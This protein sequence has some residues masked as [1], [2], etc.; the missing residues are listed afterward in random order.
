MASFA[1]VS[2][3]QLLKKLHEEWKDFI[4][5]DCLSSRHALN[6]ILTAY[7]LHEWVWAE[8]R[9]QRSYLIARWGFAEASRD[10]TPFREYITERC[11]AFDDARKIANGW[12]HFHTK[13]K[14]GQHAGAFQ[15][16]FVN[17]LGFDVDYLWIER[18][19]HEQRAEDFIRGLVE[20]WDGFFESNGL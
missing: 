7:H 18:D 14:T 19:G 13:V 1:I 15:R 4:A 6:A 2:P 9:V 8:C 17:D 10:S 20:F 16:S 11:L 12:K 3:R 5:S